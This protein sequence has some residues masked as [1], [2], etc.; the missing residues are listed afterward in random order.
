MFV[1]YKKQDGYTALE[2]YLLQNQPTQCMEG[3]NTS[4]VKKRLR[5]LGLFSLEKRRLQ[6]HSIVTSVLDSGL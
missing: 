1:Y 4:P 3:R 2:Y 6:G 5:Q